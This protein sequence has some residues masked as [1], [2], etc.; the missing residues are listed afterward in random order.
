MPLPEK[1]NLLGAEP[2]TGS[3]K[4]HFY[5]ESV[6]LFLL[7]LLLAFSLAS[8]LR[9]RTSTDM[10][11]DL[12]ALTISFTPVTSDGKTSLIAQ[13]ASVGDCHIYAIFS[14]NGQ[15]SLIF[16]PPDRLEAP[17]GKGIVSITLSP[18]LL[19][20]AKSATAKFILAVSNANLSAIGKEDLAVSKS[21][22]P[23][24]VAISSAV[25]ERFS[26][27]EKQGRARVEQVILPDE[28]SAF[29]PPPAKPSADNQPLPGTNS[30]ASSV[31]STTTNLSRPPIDRQDDAM[32]IEGQGNW[33][34]AAQGE[35][36]SGQHLQKQR[37]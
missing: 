17:V 33:G 35:K 8:I 6:A 16:P 27:L 18:E 21:S 36:V 9:T 31:S 30:P 19:H 13:V 20:S 7:S 14:D 10:A 37:L 2:L 5:W 23:S 32:P 3:R 15:S 4:I 22:A 25:W 26:D 1:T 11:N 28:L 34:Q 29:L 24:T 12:S